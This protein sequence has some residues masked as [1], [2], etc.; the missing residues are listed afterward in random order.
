VSKR[1]VSLIAAAFVIIQV[2]HA[3]TAA[4]ETE[5]AVTE[6]IVYRGQALVTRSIE[7]ELPQG[8]SEIVVKNLPNRIV[9]ESLFARAGQGATISSVRYRER[10]VKEDT[11][12]EVK[13]LDAEIE[14]V[15]TKLRHAEKAA[16]YIDKKETT[17][18]KLENFTAAAEKNDLDKGMLQFE[19]LKNLVDY[20]SG[21]RDEYQGQT[22]KIEDEILEL[23]K[24]L[25]LLRRKRDELQAGKSRTE[26]EAVLFVN[27]SGSRRVA[28]W[29]NYLVNDAS[30]LPQYNL[31]AKPDDS[32]VMVE[33]NS[34][35]H[36]AS[37]E[38]WTGVKLSLSTAQPTM[39][40]SSP[41]LEPM[42]IKLVAGGTE[43][44]EI[45]G[46]ARSEPGSGL[47]M[48][49]SKD[50]YR[51]LSAEFENLQKSRRDMSRQGKAAEQALN[52]AAQ[53]SQMAELKA[54]N[55]QVAK[56]QQQARVFARTEGISVTYNLAGKVTMPS[57]S[58]QQLI[59]IAVFDTKA[60]FLMTA[61]PLLTDYVYLQGDVVNTSDVI[62]LAGPV[63]VYNNGEFVGKGSIGTVTVGEKFT[64]G[65]GVDSQ[66]QIG[67]EF[68]DKKIDTLWRNRIE[69]YDYRLAIENYKNKKVKLRLLERIPYTKDT[70]IEITQ[71]E[72]NVP[73]SQDAEYLRTQREKGILRWDLELAPNTIEE[74]A[75][76]I[77]YTYT[78][79]YSND[80]RIQPVSV[81]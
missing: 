51:D 78:M 57:R 54:E 9:P 37:G 73:L 38:D 33:Y 30:W 48:K 8:G 80:M 59:N 75:K 15:Q 18:L 65:F 69:K 10:A 2:C 12:E 61:S 52:M 44:E 50:E 7:S 25:E 36:Q 5:G 70:G 39:A 21:K 35:I 64:T 32:K 74:R 31:R 55:K 58:D 53:Q 79:K 19:P 17:L 28:I 26:R 60:E 46:Y 45:G 13:Q 16:Q 41:V 68:K 11:R 34:I 67:R 76:I 77:T 49:R 66:I 27:N 40:A 23:K 81:R 22:V 43:Q 47:V 6:V 20:I 1:T 4:I 71:F 29:L 14:Q 72:T 56:L 24:Q 42:E 3:E 62:M 63:S